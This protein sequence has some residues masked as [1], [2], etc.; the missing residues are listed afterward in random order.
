MSEL[1]GVLNE[2][3]DTRFYLA[4]FKRFTVEEH[5][6]ST[7]QI[8]NSVQRS[9]VNQISEQ[10]PLLSDVIEQILPKKAML[11]AKAQDNIQLVVVNNEVIFYNQMNGPFYPTLRLLHKYPAMM[12][13]MQ[14]DKGAVRFVLG[15]ANIMCP[16]FT[17]A[18]GFVA[19]SIGNETPVAV[20]A[21]GKQHA[22]AIGITKMSRGDIH[23]I[24]K[25][26]A[27]ETVHYLMDGLWQTTSVQ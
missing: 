27:V 12:P 10:Y 13:R 8:K 3:V 19:E 23:S 11:I 7:S 17:S 9:I 22:M 5:V 6:S 15:G 26:I 21:E 14:C 24:N 1:T 18:G 4:M 20:Y 25:G 16:G 2:A